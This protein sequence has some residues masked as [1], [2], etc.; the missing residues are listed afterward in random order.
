M[1]S[2]WDLMV[3]LRTEGNFDEHLSVKFNN[4]NNNY[5]AALQP[6]LHN[7]VITL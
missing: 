6:V 4:E 3:S 1:K 7:N 2:L 5:Y